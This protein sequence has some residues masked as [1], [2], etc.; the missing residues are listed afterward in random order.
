[1]LK[2]VTHNDEDIDASGRGL[3]GYIN[4]SFG[5]LCYAFGKPFE[6]DGYKVDAEW[7]IEFEMPEESDRAY[8][9]ATIYNW[10]NGKNYCGEQGMSVEDIR[11]W[12]VGGD[13][14]AVELVE[15]ALQEARQRSLE[16]VPPGID[17]RFL[18]S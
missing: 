14:G 6:G 15:Q 13:R 10:K 12:H 17:P 11:E 9:V 16:E 18:N 7:T 1:M 5:E 4:A 8:V 2:F 3:K